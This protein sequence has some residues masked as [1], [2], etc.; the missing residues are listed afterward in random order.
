M[1]V[2]AVT[3]FS[4]W[5]D[6]KLEGNLKLMYDFDTTNHDFRISPSIAEKIGNSA[7]AA[8]RT[9]NRPG[10]AFHMDF[11]LDYEIYEKLR[12]GLAGYFYQQVTDDK[13]DLGRVKNDL[14]RVFGIGPHVWVPYKK[15][16]FG[17]HVIF[18][19]AARNGP[20]GINVN[21]DFAYKFF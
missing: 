20:Q 21:V 5:W 9:D 19:T 18:E 8:L 12:I 7:L 4:P 1:P 10:N 16:F 6:K 17:A 11:A 14:T 3:G 13:T 2:F 15:W